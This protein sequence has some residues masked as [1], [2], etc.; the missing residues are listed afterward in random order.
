MAHVQAEAEKGEKEYAKRTCGGR[1]YQTSNFL[2]K[3][4]VKEGPNYF[5][6]F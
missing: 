4:R 3:Q 5:S 2:S 1:I 6:G